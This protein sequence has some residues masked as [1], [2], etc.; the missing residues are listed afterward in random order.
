MGDWTT[1]TGAH[2]ILG[3]PVLQTLRTKYRDHYSVKYEILVGVWTTRTGAHPILGIPLLP[4]LRT[5]YR[6][7]S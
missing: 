3:I 2:P 7:H 4:T 5:K 6:D 1:R